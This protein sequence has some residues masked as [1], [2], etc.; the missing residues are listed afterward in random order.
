[1]SAAGVSV[2]GTAFLMGETGLL[3]LGRTGAGKSQLVARLSILASDYPIRLVA[4]DRVLL[5]TASGRIIAR[6][7]AG[8][9]GKI[10][11]R[12]FGIADVPAMPSCVL[13]GIVRLVANTPIELPR[14]PDDPFETEQISGLSLPSIRLPEGADT[15]QELMARWPFF[16]SS[17]H[18]K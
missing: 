8:F 5:T 10:E 1:M 16:Q 6:P 17:I 4:D 9:L 2:H 12:G 14:L 13:R 7:V 3:A 11:L 18:S 15:A